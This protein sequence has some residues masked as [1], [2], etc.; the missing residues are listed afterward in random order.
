MCIITTHV[1]AVDTR[2]SLPSPS[3]RPGDK[4]MQLQVQ[5]YLITETSVESEGPFQKF[6]L[7]VPTTMVT[8]IQAWSMEWTLHPPTAWGML[9][10]GQTLS[11]YLWLQMECKHYRSRDQ[12]WWCH[13]KPQTGYRI[14]LAHTITSTRKPAQVKL[15]TVSTPRI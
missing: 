8:T 6:F 12:P 1:H 11:N 4:A 5:L 3:W 13:R 2:P 7:N 10:I 14:L 9:L 15:V